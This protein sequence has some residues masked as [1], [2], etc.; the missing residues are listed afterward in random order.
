[1]RIRTARG[2]VN[3]AARDGTV[4]LLPSAAKLAV[5]QYRV[6]DRARLRAGFDAASAEVR[7]TPRWRRSWASSS[8]LQLSPHSAQGCA[9]QLAQFGPP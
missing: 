7:Q 6:L 4:L 9:G 1:M 8:L 2:W 3:T 5:L